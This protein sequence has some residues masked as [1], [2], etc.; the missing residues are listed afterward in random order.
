MNSSF[1]PRHT[2]CDSMEAMIK[3]KML[4]KLLSKPVTQVEVQPMNGHGGLAGGHLSYVNTNDGRLVLKQMSI[5]TDWIMFA[6][7]DQQCRSVTL[8]QYGILDQLL[9]HAEHKTIACARDGRGWAILMHDLTGSTFSWETPLNYEIVTTFLDTLARLHATFWNRTDIAD[10][11]LGVC[12]PKQ[13]LDQTALPVARDHRNYPTSPIPG[14]VCGGWE[15]LPE[16]LEP[17]V[18]ATL[19]NLIEDPQPL[20]DALKRYPGTLLHGDYRIENLAY[21]NRC[22][23]LFDWQ[24]SAY[25]VMTTDLAWML[26]QRCVQMV[27]SREQATNYYRSRLENYLGKPFDE[28]EWQAMHDLGYC[29][30]ALRSIPFSAFFYRHSD[31]PVSKQFYAQIVKQL[32]Q[33]V[34]DALRWF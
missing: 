4:S 3:P 1:E 10:P 25:T 6:S 14:W 2:L 24:E 29:L 27:M 21:H 13:L 7:D 18:L 11:S 26:K 30:D 16:L 15:A 32:G 20:Y 22:P 17:V 19:H 9:P 8:W 31:D 28:Y 33:F 34:L 5:E 23:V 12:T